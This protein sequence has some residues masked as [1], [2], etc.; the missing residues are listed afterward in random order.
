VLKIFQPAYFA[1]RDFDEKGKASLR[2]ING[3]VADYDTEVE[4]AILKNTILVERRALKDLGLENN[5]FR[6][7]LHSYAECFKGTNARRTLGA[8][9]P[10]C[11]QQLTGLSFLNTYASLF[12]KQSGFKNAFLITTILSELRCYSSSSLQPLTTAMHAAIIAL[13]S[14]STL[15]LLTDRFGRRIIVFVAAIVC[16]VTMLVL[17]ILGFVPK[18]APLQN[19]LI[20]TACVWSFFNVARE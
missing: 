10:I 2:R 6:E 9:L 7:L 5:S 12:F 1:N 18:T 13:M 16:T 20:F 4:Y 11:A 14:S 8:A 17:G 19:F 3:K 15:V